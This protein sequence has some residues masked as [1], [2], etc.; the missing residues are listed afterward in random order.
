MIDCEKNLISDS[1]HRQLTD[2]KNIWLILQPDKPETKSYTSECSFFIGQIWSYKATDSDI[3]QCRHAAAEK[4]PRGGRDVVVNSL[5]RQNSTSR[6]MTVLKA[7]INSDDLN[8]YKVKLN[9]KVEIFSLSNATGGTLLSLLWSNHQVSQEGIS[10][11]PLSGGNHLTKGQHPWTTTSLFHSLH[12]AFKF[13]F[14][15][16]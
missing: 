7:K 1:F 8:W 4:V 2:S 3:V 13:I 14:L 15:T 5:L 9:S 12:L 10:D 16:V 11:I 6:Y